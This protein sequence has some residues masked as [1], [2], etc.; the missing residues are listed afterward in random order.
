MKM[1]WLARVSP[2]LLLSASAVGSENLYVGAKVGNVTAD[3]F[4]PLVESRTAIDDSDTS[5]GLFVGYHI[6]D[7]LAIEGGYNYLGEYDLKDIAGGSYEASS[8]DVLLKASGNVTDSLALYAKGGVAIYDWNANG[9]G[10]ES[11]D[12]GVAATVAFGSE[13]SITPAMKL[14][15]EYQIYSDVGGV[16]INSFNVA[17][18]HYF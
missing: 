16:N 10:V 4:G 17:L 7:T 18:S 1:Q 5:Y 3:N 13:Y 2:L 8:F 14:G 11:D 15:L 9:T 12:T 6:V